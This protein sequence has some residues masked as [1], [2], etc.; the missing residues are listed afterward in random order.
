VACLGHPPTIQTQA[1]AT[2]WARQK[3]PIE[4]EKKMKKEPEKRKKRRR[5]VLA[6]NGFS[7]SHV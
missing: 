5:V 2:V 1:L 7:G 3:S 4:K 6:P